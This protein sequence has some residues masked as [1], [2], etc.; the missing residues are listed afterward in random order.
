LI[1][2][3]A[4]WYAIG[5]RQRGAPVYLQAPRAYYV[6]ASTGSDS[7]D[8]LSSGTAFAT[9]QKAVNTVLLFNMNG[10]SVTIYVADGTYAPALLPPL[11]GAGTASIIGN[12][13]SAASCV[14]QSGAGS[15]IICEGKNWVLA[16]FR[17]I[18]GAPGSGDP[19]FGVWSRGTGSSISVYNLD[20]G[21]CYN[22]HLVATEAGRISVLGHD[23]DPTYYIKISGA[24]RAHMKATNAGNIVCNSPILNVTTPVTLIAFC[25]VG[26]CG[27]ISGNYYSQVNP[28]NVT[29]P[30]YSITLNGVLDSNGAGTSMWPGSL[31]GGTATGGQS[32]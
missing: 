30:K 25:E 20:F 26:V 16:G 15:A 32:I 10:Y 28:S 5:V 21:F 12:L 27:T 14:I 9:I 31:A 2:D 17:P 24:A 7:N 22:G 1:Y 11:N 23:N 13:A 19:G 4:A 8:G 6:N 3:G 18:V 29:G